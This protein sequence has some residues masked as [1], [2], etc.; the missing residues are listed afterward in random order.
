M[1]SFSPRFCKKY[2]VIM[3]VIRVKM[4]KSGQFLMI[5]EMYSNI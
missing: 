5:C 1:S 4:V 3:L 2:R